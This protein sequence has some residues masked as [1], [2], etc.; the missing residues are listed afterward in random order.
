MYFS[1]CCISDNICHI[2]QNWMGWGKE[3][4]K[5]NLWRIGALYFLPFDKSAKEKNGVILSKL[6]TDGKKNGILT[7]RE[8]QLLSTSTGKELLEIL[9]YTHQHPVHWNHAL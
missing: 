9:K 3:G 7:D 5:N 8:E 2:T 1:F 4:R 6:E